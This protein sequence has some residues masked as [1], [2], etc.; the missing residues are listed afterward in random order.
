MTKK[1][2]LD[3]AKFI[4]SH[5][6][7]KVHLKWFGGEPLCNPEVIDTISRYLQGRGVA[8]DASMVSNGYLIDQQDP[9][10]IKKLWKLNRVQI[11]LDGTQ[12]AYNRTK[13]YVKAGNA[14]ERVL[15]N[16]EYLLSIGIRVNVRLNLSLDNYSDLLILSD[17]LQDRFGKYTK[18]INV[19]AHPLF[20]G[21]LFQPTETERK[22]LYDNYIA[23]LNYINATDIG[24][25]V[26]VP[27][28]RH[29]QCMA[30]DGKSTVILPDGELSLCEHHCDDE[31]YGT[32]YSDE[33]NQD[34]IQSWSELADELEGCGDCFY[35]PACFRLKKCPAKMVCSSEYRRF[36][37]N[38]TKSIMMSEYKRKLRK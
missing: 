6:D 16:I 25:P 13:N 27:R 19:Y 3:V 35:Y 17:M 31:M 36:I 37:Q 1:T 22:K 38:K 2:A 15:K 4:E 9:E 8:Y 11:T 14:F 34:V 32:I 7:S 30:D 33:Y 28:I 5:C 29:T 10:K 21:K 24:S 26:G 12:E 18:M 23:L 20:E